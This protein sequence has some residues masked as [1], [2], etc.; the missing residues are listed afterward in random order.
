MLIIIKNAITNGIIGIAKNTK[1]AVIIAESKLQ[2]YIFEIKV[3]DR[4]IMI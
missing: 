2:P 3:D 4:S 1:E